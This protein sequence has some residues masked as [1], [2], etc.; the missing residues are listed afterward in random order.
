[1]RYLNVHQKLN[2]RFDDNQIDKIRLSHC[3]KSPFTEINTKLKEKKRSDYTRIYCLL[4]LSV[5][6]LNMQIHVVHLVG[7]VRSF[8]V[9]S[10]LELTHKAVTKFNIC[11]AP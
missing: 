3:Y 6:A 8:S 2:F 1:M 11:L 4:F 7:H 5:R 10:D 9:L